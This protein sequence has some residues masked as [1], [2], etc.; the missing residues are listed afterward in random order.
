MV[1]CKIL[2]RGYKMEQMINKILLEWSLRVHDGMPNKDNP[3]HIVQL[4]ETLSHMKLTDDVTNLIIQNL[5]EE[6]QK[7][8]S[9]SKDTDRIVVYTNKEKWHQGWRPNKKSCEG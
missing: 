7:F 3:L 9:R 4:R 6:E 2:Q 5:T 8:Y 1:K